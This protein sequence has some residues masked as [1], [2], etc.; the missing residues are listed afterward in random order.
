MA[1]TDL[2][3]HMQW[4]LGYNACPGQRLARIELS[5][6]TATLVRDYDIRLVD[7]SK[8]WRYKTYFTVVPEDWPVYVKKTTR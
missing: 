8:Q 2:V 7:S 4:G 6:I 1:N 5:K 3:V